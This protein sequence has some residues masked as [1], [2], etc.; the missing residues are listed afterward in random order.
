M[1]LDG[2]LRLLERYCGKDRHHPGLLVS[3]LLFRSPIVCPSVIYCPS[4]YVQGQSFIALDDV[5]ALVASS[6]IAWYAYRRGC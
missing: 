5:A 4:T 6:G 3:R 1:G 2:L